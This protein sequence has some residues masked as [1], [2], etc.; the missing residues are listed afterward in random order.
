MT[1]VPAEQVLSTVTSQ[2]N[3][4][5]QQDARIATAEL[6]HASERA[7]I[8]SERHAAAHDLGQALLPV[9]DNASIASAAQTTGMVGLPSE[10][11]LDTLRGRRAY[12]VARLAAIYNDVRYAQRELLRHPRTGSLSTAIAEA[13]DLRG[14]ASNVV[15]TCEGHLDFQ[16]LWDNGYGTDANRETW[17]RYSYWKDHSSAKAIVLLFEGKTTFAEV[18]AE[19]TRAKE[20]L[21]VYDAELQTLRAEVAAGE[22]LEREYAALYEEH[23]TLDARAL[24]FTRGRL[25]Q[26]LV[27]SDPSLVSQRLRAT[28]A[29]LLLF[30][31]ASGLSAKSSYL[32][33]IQQKHIDELRKDVGT[34]RARLDAIEER[35]RRKWAPMPLDKFQKLAEERAPKYESRWQRFGKV[36]TTVGA[37]DR[38]DHARGYDD[39]LWWDLMTRGRYD[40]S[41][42]GDVSAF[43]ARHPDY[44]FDPD[45]KNQ[46][47]AISV[48]LGDL[49]TDDDAYAGASAI[50]ADADQNDALDTRTTD[51]S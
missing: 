38:W 49:H 29:L 14:P 15:A 22:A 3:V 2:R 40:G 28:P 30:L 11:V 45:W 47:A 6:Y 34:Q 24:D 32:D 5:A 48:D 35:T 21:L 43:H 39:L 51:A 4:L 27:T 50:E 7:K 8:A 16:R 37:Y 13:I 26:H 44:I 25:V 41:Y 36:Y 33:A 12:L 46:A 18:R 23:R 19:Y 31:R 10:N 1:W 42:I 20:T 17:W 9:L